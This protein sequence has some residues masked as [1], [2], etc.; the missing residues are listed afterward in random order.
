[1]KPSPHHDLTA[2]NPKSEAKKFFSISTRRLAESAE[3]LNSSVAQ[4][5]DELQHCKG[6]QNKWRKQDLK[7]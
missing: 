4:S 2:E 3:G 7:G 1:V 6:L 5:A